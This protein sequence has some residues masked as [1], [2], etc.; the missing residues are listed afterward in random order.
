[1]TG[2]RQAIDLRTGVVSTSATWK[3]TDGHTAAFSYQ[4]FTD[5]ADEHGGVVQLQLVPGWSG[6]ATVTDEIDGSPAT[7]TDPVAKGSNPAARQD[8]VEVVTQRTGIDAAIASELATSPN[9]T[10]IPTGVD[11][12]AGQSIGQQ[13]TFPVVAGQTY[14]VTKFVGVDDSQDTADPVGAA[15]AE[16]AGAAAAGL[17]AALSAN[18]AAW[19]ALWKG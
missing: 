8:Y 13:L 14:T 10:A 16:A 4:V 18:D 19:A 1:M 3:A 17:P 7:L 5:R 9:I 6:T 15:Q 12:T 11:A 2:W